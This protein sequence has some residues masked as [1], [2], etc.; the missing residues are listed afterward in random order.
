MRRRPGQRKALGAELKQVE[1]EADPCAREPAGTRPTRPRRLA[2]RCFAR[3]VRP[4]AAGA[5]TSRC[6]ATS[7]THERGARTSAFACLSEKATRPSSS[8]ALVALGP[9]KSFGAEGFR[10]GRSPISCASRRSTGT[11]FL[12]NEQQHLHGA[13]RRPAYFA[14]TFRAVPLRHLYTRRDSLPRPTPPCATPASRRASPEAGAAGK[15]TSGLS[16]HQFDK[17]SRCSRSSGGP[18]GLARNTSGIS[19]RGGLM[20]ARSGLPPYNMLRVVN[21]G[22]WTTSG[23]S[24][25]GKKYDVEAVASGPGELPRA[26]VRAPNTNRLPGAPPSTRALPAGVGRHGHIADT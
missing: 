5:T 25:R 9:G 20:Q 11:G 14:G 19:P 12:P 4:G 8:L 26:H 15:D 21:I 13:R 3:S 6:S 22:S 2:K 24:A 17:G 16:V 7:S 23:A 18:E 1:E 10:A